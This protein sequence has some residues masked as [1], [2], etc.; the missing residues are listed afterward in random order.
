MSPA[1]RPIVS[2]LTQMSHPREHHD[3]DPS[4]H[5]HEHTGGLHGLA[6]WTIGPPWHRGCSPQPL[7][8]MPTA[9]DTRSKG[10]AGSDAEAEP[11]P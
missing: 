2:R 1:S 8:E 3:H 4:E 5:Q 9:H 6:S 11:S 10:W 7:L